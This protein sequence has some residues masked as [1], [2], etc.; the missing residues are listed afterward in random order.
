MDKK[1]KKEGSPTTP[2][3]ECGAP[4]AIKSGSQKSAIARGQG[5]CCPAPA[6][7][8]RLRRAR[9]S[10]ER[11]AARPVQAIACGMCGAAI[12]SPTPQETAAFNRG[13]VV[14]CSAPCFNARRKQINRETHARRKQRQHAVLKLTCEICGVRIEKPNRGHVAA[15]KRG[16]PVTCGEDCARA[17]HAKNELAKYHTKMAGQEQAKLETWLATAPKTTFVPAGVPHPNSILGCPFAT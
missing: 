17:L 6:P 10:R 3:T 7:C 13:F 15:H 1:T 5:L 14:T 16:F 9:W 2:C 4:V 12:P 8:V 11:Y